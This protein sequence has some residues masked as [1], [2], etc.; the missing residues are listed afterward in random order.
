MEYTSNRGL[1]RGFV[2][3]VIY[4]TALLALL[5]LLGPREEY[6]SHFSCL[7]HTPS[8][9]HSIAHVSWLLLMVR[10]LMGKL[11]V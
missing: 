8:V 6:G 11:Q 4:P 9:D 5:L 3:V 2:L 7:P 1:R 10:W